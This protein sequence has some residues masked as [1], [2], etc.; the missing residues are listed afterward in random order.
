MNRVKQ[1]IKELIHPPLLFHFFFMELK[2]AKF[3]SELELQNDPKAI[4]KE[5]KLDSLTL[6]IKPNLIRF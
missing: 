5:A 4:I 1:K 3:K 2:S 6:K